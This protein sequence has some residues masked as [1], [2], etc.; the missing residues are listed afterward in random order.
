M[1]P[2]P[3][4]AHLLQRLFFLLLVRPF[5]V[6]FIGLRVRGREHLPERASPT[7]CGAGPA[8][9]SSPATS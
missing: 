5:L 3:W 1:S 6:L 8:P 2:R 4:W 7:C 9:S